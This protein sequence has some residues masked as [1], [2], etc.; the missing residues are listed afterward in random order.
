MVYAH[1]LRAASIAMNLKI[2]RGVTHESIKI[3]QVVA[4]NH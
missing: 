4:Q 2:Y 1:K 3:G